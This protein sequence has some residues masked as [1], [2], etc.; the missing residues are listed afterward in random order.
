[1]K[2]FLFLLVLFLPS[3][4]LEPS[5]QGPYIVS[6]VVDGDT[7]NIEEERIRLA[8]INSPEIGQCYA[9]EAKEKLQELTLS[10]EVLLEKE[11]E[12]KDKY[13]RLLRYVYTNVTSISHYLV[14]YG[15]A[16][17]YDKY[18]AT[19]RYYKELK[20]LE[21]EA[22]EQKRGVWNCTDP[23][24]GCLYVAS[25]NS[26]LYHKPECKWAK[27]IKPENLICFHS[28]EELQGYSPAQSC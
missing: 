2:L 14:H 20:L 1:M 24:Q 22:Q 3:C 25:K 17:V 7:L 12:N 4:R 13:G 16:T 28:K 10:Q 15:Y 23:L 5:L 9:Q 26:N 6:S 19:T 8:G 18:N 21:Q 11:L 27:R